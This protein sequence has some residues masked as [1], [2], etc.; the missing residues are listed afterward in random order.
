MKSPGGGELNSRRA[1]AQW[2]RCDRVAHPAF[3]SYQTLYGST[4]SGNINDFQRSFPGDKATPHY[5]NNHT[6]NH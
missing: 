3:F 5:C 2:D 4:L 6:L 1:K